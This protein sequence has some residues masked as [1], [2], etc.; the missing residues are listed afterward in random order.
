LKNLIEPPERKVVQKTESLI[1][2][3]EREE[4]E[5]IGVIEE[6]SLKRNLMN[7]SLKSAE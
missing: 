3:A 7:F 5:E 2:E 6:R 4:T 1:A